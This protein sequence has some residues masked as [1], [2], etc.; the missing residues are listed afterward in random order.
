MS[1]LFSLVLV[2]LV[3]LSAGS[4]GASNV[5]GCA[6]VHLLQFGGRP[7]AQVASVAT[8]NTALSEMILA[9]KTPVCNAKMT[10]RSP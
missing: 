4:R 10:P 2:G 1:L 6:T 3:R 7:F 8:E 5:D 9:P